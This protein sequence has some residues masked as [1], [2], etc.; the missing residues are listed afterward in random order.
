MGDDTRP[1]A[2]LGLPSQPSAYRPTIPRTTTTVA[3]MVHSCRSDAGVWGS[4]QT[5]RLW[6]IS[7][8]PRAR[9]QRRRPYLQHRLHYHLLVSP[10]SRGPGAHVS[11]VAERVPNRPRVIGPA[12]CMMQPS[13]TSLVRA[14]LRDS[15]PPAWRGC[16]RH[17]VCET[18]V[19]STASSMPR[20]RV[21]A[22]AL[23]SG[24]VTC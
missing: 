6:S 8:S 17:L 13:R 14:C 21:A 15:C 4:R 10:P 2:I 7:P 20:V 18:M 1:H 12:P 19:L 3:G 22:T 5:P 9:R 16:S 24:W 23:N 11:P